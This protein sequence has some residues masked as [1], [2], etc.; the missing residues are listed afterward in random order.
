M[1]IYLDIYKQNIFYFV[2][3]IFEI[4]GKI[5]C[6]FMAEIYKRMYFRN[7]DISK[8]YSSYNKIN[9]NLKHYMYI[10]RYT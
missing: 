7:G 2:L 6:D 3:I 4:L 5:T 10:S 8:I 9:K 1:Y